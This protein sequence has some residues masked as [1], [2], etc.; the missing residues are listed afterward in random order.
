MIKRKQENAHCLLIVDDNEDNR[1][2][3]AHYFTKFGYQVVPAASGKE[4]IEVLAKYNIDLVLLDIVMPEMDGFEVLREIRNKY[5]VIKMPVIMTTSLSESSDVIKALTLGANDYISKPIEPRVADAR[6]QTHL[7]LKRLAAE[8]DHLMD[9]ASHDIKKP[10]IVIE[11]ITRTIQDDNKD[12]LA[13]NPSMAELLS[14]L[15]K[16]SGR[17]NTFVQDFL[18]MRVI[19]NG[20]MVLNQ[21]RCNLNALVIEVVVKLQ[22]V[23]SRKCITIET[24]LGDDLP[25]VNIDENRISQVLENLIGNAIKFSPE[26]LKVVVSTKSKENFVVCNISDQGPG[27]INEDKPKLFKRF[28]R[29]SNKPTANESST[30]LGLSICKELIDLHNG[31]I[32][33]ENNL[34]KGANFRFTI[35]A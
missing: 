22:A 33:V 5:S 35:P 28:S 11:E 32:A 30:G 7:N 3:L 6:I 27:I 31:T 17:L 34:D 10:V 1:A 19:E 21:S 29:L 20:N 2:I 23:A 24:K 8:R 15:S 16:T 9:M 14:L 18:E 4:A 25:I 13:D 12:L 26:N